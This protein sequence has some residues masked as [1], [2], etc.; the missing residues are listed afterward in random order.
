MCTGDPVLCHRAVCAVLRSY[1]AS[2]ALPALTW[3]LHCT[4]FTFKWR[5]LY[6]QNKLQRLSSE[7]RM[8]LSITV[9]SALHCCSS[10]L[11]TLNLKWAWA[12]T[13]KSRI[14][15]SMLYSDR[16]YFRIPYITQ[17]SSLPNTNKTIWNKDLVPVALN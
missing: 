4:A 16:I 14:V 6:F 11:T 2:A 9:R 3:P 13:I 10:K 1:P 15:A 8:L 12:N 7:F 5:I 17:N